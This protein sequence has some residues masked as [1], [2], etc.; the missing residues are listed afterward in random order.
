ML[1]NFDG[2]LFDMD[3][4]ITKNAH[5][6]D[7]AWEKVMLERYGY[8]LQIGDPRVHGG[9]T[10]FI[11]ESLL[12]RS[13]SEAE[14]AEFHEYKEATYRDF[15]RGSLA[16]MV[17]LLE[18]LRR[19]EHKKIALVTSADQTNTQ[20]VLGALGLQQTF[21]VR[22]LGEDVQ[23]GKPDP[24]PF[25]LGAQKLGLEPARCVAFEDSLAGVQSASKAG[26]FVV[27]VMSWQSEQALLQAGAKQVIADYLALV[28]CDAPSW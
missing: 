9:K 6:H 11:T 12:G 19:L 17:G 26:C 25:L 16:P 28:G 24:E 10:K 23:H 1:G 18:F 8:R 14:A 13:I 2:F 7:L 4:T 3:G 15:A 5:F 22:V 27:G 20:F 21:A